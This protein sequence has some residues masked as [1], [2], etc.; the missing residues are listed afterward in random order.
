MPIKTQKRIR[1]CLDTPNKLG[2][3]EEIDKLLEAYELLKLNQEKINII[4]RTTMSKRL[5]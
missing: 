5:K 3:L 1:E 2:N 4:N